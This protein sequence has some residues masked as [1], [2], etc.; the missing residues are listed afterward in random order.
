MRLILRNI[1]C[2]W[3][4]V[5]VPAF[6]QTDNISFY[7]EVDTD[8]LSVD[9]F[10]RLSLT[11]TGTQSLT[12]IP[13]PVVDGFDV[14]YLGPATR[15]SIINGQSFATHSYRYALYPLKVGKFQIPAITIDINGKNYSTKPI[16]IEVVAAGNMTAGPTTPQDNAVADG[17]QGKVFATMTTPQQEVYVG[18]SIP[19]TIRL[20]VSGMSISDIEYPKLDENGFTVGEFKEPRQ[21]QQVIG[22]ARFDVLEF[23]LEVFPSRE[24]AISLGK[25]KVGCQILYRSK[26]DGRIPLDDFDSLFDSD[27]FDSF[28]NFYERRPI[29][30]E[31]TDLMVN[32]LPLPEEGKPE[33]FSGAVGN[34]DF[35]VSVTPPE[36]NVG[37]PVTV[38]MK[39]T[40][41]NLR[42][43]AA[44]DIKA[45]GFKFYDPQVKD[46]RG[47]KTVEQVA[48]PTTEN[49]KEFP[50]VSFSYF[51]PSERTYKTL[52][53]G[54]FALTVHSA[55]Q[56]LK[57][58]G[59][60]KE[61]E[62]LKEFKPEALGKDILFI[63]ENPDTFHRVGYRLYNNTLFWV[64]VWLLLLAW[65]GAYGLYRRTHRLRTDTA[66]A[67]RLLAPR[68]AREGL[69]QARQAL[70]DKKQPEF[71]QSVFRTLREYLADKFHRPA[72]GLTFES[73]RPVL[74]SWS[75]RPEDVQAV[76]SI[77]EECDMARY[78]AL[79]ADSQKMAQVLRQLEQVIDH[80]ERV[81]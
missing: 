4:V 31:S 28:L 12:Q 7:A 50:A 58:V 43:V 32:V 64:M 39:I 1:L 76:R 79:T 45:E 67:R 10:A 65:A 71:Y 66:Y 16:D 61:G 15:I 11:I 20:F 18:Q 77:L 34:F 3:F 55:A 27:F 78:A 26:K 72:A 25:A 47:T 17:L 53:K 73:I 51:D 68:K 6:A 52:T 24:G 13:V 2:V 37:D 29:T 57:V 35:D 81:K 54:P 75:V 46:E 59:L 8:K 9:S 42:S 56:G 48:I 62:V 5:A 70:A 80:I 33:D 63:K 69:A 44:P 23:N 36:V 30:V 60:E 38:R 14:K 22:G 49:I 41:D 40:G 21:Y 74:E 19:V